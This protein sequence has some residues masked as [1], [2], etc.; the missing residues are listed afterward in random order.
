MLGLIRKFL[1][2]R[3]RYSGKTNKSDVHN[4]CHYEP[5]V[6]ALY[7]A[8][9]S[10]SMSAF[11][12]LVVPVLQLIYGTMQKQAHTR[13]LTDQHFFRLIK[14][15]SEACRRLQGIRM[16]MGRPGVDYRHYETQYSYALITAMAIYWCRE[17]IIS[18]QRDPQVLARRYIPQEGLLRLQSDAMVW[19][20]WQAFFSDGDD[21]GL[22]KIAAKAEL[23]LNQSNVLANGEKPL[24]PRKTRS[25]KKRLLRPEKSDYARA[26]ALG[27]RSVDRIC[28]GLR[29]GILSYNQVDSLVHVD[30]K[31][32]TFLLVPQIFQWCSRRRYE[33]DRSSTL[34]NR[35]FRL[36]IHTHEPQGEGIYYGVYPGNPRHFRGAVIEDKSIFWDNKPPVSDFLIPAFNKK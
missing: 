10:L 22:K 23:S 27:W 19:A 33:Q 9:G 18:D 24:R 16:P 29:S 21:G 1:P 7:E 26:D 6:M 30:N 12:R 11:K 32:R 15:I 28:K 20:D 13:E 3:F 31:G 4:E 14:D 17:R 36:H 5:L 8:D 34:K 2:P 25:N 35:F